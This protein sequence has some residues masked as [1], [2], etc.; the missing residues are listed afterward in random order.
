MQVK[1]LAFRLA[2]RVR[3]RGTPHRRLSIR[4]RLMVAVRFR[5]GVCVSLWVS[6]RAGARVNAIP[7]P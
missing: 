7:N 3:L 5:V 4:V 1:I 2:V 6:A